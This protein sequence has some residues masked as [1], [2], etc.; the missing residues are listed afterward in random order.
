MPNY[1]NASYLREAVESVLKQTFHD[2][3]LV[4]VD[5]GSYD[6]SVELLQSFKDRR[7]SIV[8]NGR[9]RGI[10]YSRNKAIS[11]T[12]GKYV[13]WLDSDDVA[14][15]DRLEK[16]FA[17]LE[18]NDQYGLCCSNVATID[19]GS[20]PLTGSLWTKTEL[21]LNWILLWTNPIAQ[22]SVMVRRSCIAESEGPY[23]EEFSPAEDYDLWCRLGLQ[24]KLYRLDETLLYYRIL[25]SSAYHTNEGKALKGSLKRNA[26]YAEAIAE[27]KVPE[28][29]QYLTTFS[30]ILPSYEWGIDFRACLDWLSAVEKGFGRRFALEACERGAVARDINAR[31]FSLL[32]EHHGLVRGRSNRVAIFEQRP[33]L[34][35][36]LTLLRFHKL[37]LRVFRRAISASEKMLARKRTQNT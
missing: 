22:S 9:N 17:F 3:E 36:G 1:N 2:F 33:L 16:Q 31:L 35:F 6:N 20:K 23:L 32:R 5:D 13:A 8:L 10:A 29:H 18:G 30:C 37:V 27:V 26:E 34:F 19:E 25:S 14:R 28:F 4:V 21:P 11:V 24:T 7:I 15:A 12:C